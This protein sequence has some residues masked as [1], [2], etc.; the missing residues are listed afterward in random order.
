M[1]MT[2]GA[3]AGLIMGRRRGADTHLRAQLC[4]QRVAVE[5]LATLGE[6]VHQDVVRDEP[7]LSARRAEGVEDLESGVEGA[8][9]D[10]ALEEHVERPRRRAV[11]RRSQLVED[12]AHR[13]LRPPAKTA[14]SMA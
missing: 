2:R 6:R 13:P 10:E 14:C 11:P 3:T 1:G 8:G 7:G 4:R 9:G 5:Q 12:L